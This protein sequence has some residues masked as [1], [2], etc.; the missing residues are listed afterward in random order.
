MASIPERLW[1]NP[2]C[3]RRE[4]RWPYQRQSPSKR[5]EREAKSSNC[6]ALFLHDRDFHMVIP[7]ADSLHPPAFAVA[8]FVSS[9]FSLLLV[10]SRV[11]DLATPV[12]ALK[13]ASH[14]PPYL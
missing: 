9:K 12:R 7:V 5:Q 1:R 10:T 8:G 3:E 11:V 2:R 13:G 6:T 4:H 14:R